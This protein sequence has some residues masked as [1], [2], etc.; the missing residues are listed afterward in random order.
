MPKVKEVPVVESA[1]EANLS[2]IQ[3]VVCIFCLICSVGKIEVAKREVEAKALVAPLY[4]W[5]A[6]VPSDTCN[7]WDVGIGLPSPVALVGW[8]LH[9][10]E[11]CTVEA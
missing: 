2:T 8:L 3:F 1:K 7:L 5:G 4:T 11:C 10:V 9:K 6:A